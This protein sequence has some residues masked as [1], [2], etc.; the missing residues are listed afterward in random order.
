[1]ADGQVIFE[2]TGDSTKIDMTIQ[3]VTS[4]IKT[5]SQKWENDANGAMKNV[6]AESEG[7]S[8]IMK[9]AFSGAFMA[10]TTT[11]ISATADILKAFGE[12]TMA[13][14]DMASDLEE[15]QNVV[16]VTFGEAGAK[17]IDTWAKKAGTQFGLT[18]L[19][20]K[21]YTATLGAMMK[22]SGMTGDE[23]VSMSTD[24]AGLAADMASFYNLDFDTAFSKIRSGISGETEPLKQLG[25]NMSVDN[26]NAFL[27][28]I[29]SEKQ[30]NSMT[31]AEQLLT[32]YQYI[33]QATSDAQGDFA[34]TA[35]DSYANINRQIETQS[36]K[37]QE[38]WGQEAL[39]FA[40]RWQK[41]WLETLRWLNG[42]TG[43]PITGT[44]NQLT[45]WIDEQTAAAEDARNE[46]N[47]LAETYAELFDMDPSEYDNGF[48]GS[49][50]EYFYE[51]L[52]AQQP[53]AGGKQRE[54]IDSILAQMDAAYG[55]IDEAEAKVRDFQTQLD[56]LLSETPDAEGTGVDIGQQVADGLHS[57]ITAIQAE[58]DEINSI[59]GEIGNGAPDGITFT[60]VGKYASGLNYVPRDD[61]PALL[62]EGE[63]VLTAQ[64]NKIWQRFKNGSSS[65]MDYDALGGVMRDNIRAG[66]NVYLDGR[67][68]G[69]VISD[70]QGQSYR[71]LQRSGW[72][73]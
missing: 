56:Q 28:S 4:T 7:T 45:S 10:V 20:A 24:L 44:Q 14:I 71:N 18:E 49:F 65:G 54:R 2:I 39:P 27:D 61:F 5:E 3:Q 6:G 60:T 33:L 12:W 68:V 53:F 63:A 73:G 67:T 13:A 62:H 9:S 15:V 16:D 42:D 46:L 34:K 29:G 51:T 70:M 22:S 26:L 43:V 8:E 40:K 19:Q 11:V 1:M 69:K 55:K 64:E 38:K 30:F 52:R 57:K 41:E 47:S 36:A 23:I 21:K 25:I 50:G 59:L 72:Q 32:R 17:K 37:L 58:V 35:N 31:Q 66:G 48:Y